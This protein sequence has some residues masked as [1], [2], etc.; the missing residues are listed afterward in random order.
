MAFVY[1]KLISGLNYAALSGDNCVVLS[2]REALYYPLPMTTY[3]AA[4][5]AGFFSTTSAG[6]FNS[7]HFAATLTN[8]VTS[9]LQSLYFGFCTGQITGSDFAFVGMGLPT[10]QSLASTVTT[11]LFPSSPASISARACKISAAHSAQSSDFGGFGLT[12]PVSSTGFYTYNAVEFN[13]FGTTKAY[14]V[15][16]STTSDA[17]LFSPPYGAST[18]DISTGKL[19]SLM[20]GNAGAGGT[21]S[22]WFTD[23]GTQGG[24]LLPIPTAVVVYSPFYNS[25]LRIH[26]FSVIKTR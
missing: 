1:T 4:K 13:L 3:G 20:T 19:W 22:G 9:R 23:D 18:A 6:D 7:G 26:N 25:R 12:Y 14:T 10:G 24:N 16:V 5:V 17:T 15:T 21:L 2:P 8:G 11:T